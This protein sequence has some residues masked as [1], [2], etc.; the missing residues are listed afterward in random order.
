VIDAAQDMLEVRSG[1]MLLEWWAI[2]LL[3][4]LAIFAVNRFVPPDRASNLLYDAVQRMIPRE[5]SDDILIV[6]IDNHS[7]RELGRWPWRRELHADLMGKLTEAGVRAVGYDIL[8]LEP[9]PV[10]RV[11]RALGAA[12]AAN[13]QTVV[14]HLIE[15]PGRDGRPSDLIAPI[16]AISGSVRT[17]AHVVTRPDRDGVV[18]GVDRLEDPMGRRFLHLSE[19]LLAIAA[20][21]DATI[22]APDPEPSSRVLAPV[23][24]LIP[25]ARGPGAYA[26]V[27]FVDVVRGQVPIELLHDRIILVGATAAG[28]GD[29]F[30]TPMSGTEETM[31][32]VEIHANY[33]DALQAG[34]LIRTAP[35][36]AVQL[37]SLVPLWLLMLSLLR[38]GP[39]INLWLG[40][41]LG[42]VVVLASFLAL[43]VFRLW[44]PPATGLA[45][46]ALIFPLWGWRRLDVANSYMIRELRELTAEQPMLP[47]HRVELRGD[48]VAR[49]IV[50]MH[51][52]IR[53]VRDLRQFI[54]QS[55]DNLPDA[56]LITDLDGRVLIANAAAERLFG[57]RIGGQVEGRPLAAVFATLDTDPA[58][59]DP[60]AAELLEALRHGNLPPDHGYETRLASGQSLEIRLAFFTDAA[61]HPLGWIARFVDITDLRASE[62]QREDALRLLTHD[63]RS[64]QAALLAVLDAEKGRV[65]QDVA[66]RLRR[67][68]HLTLGLAD[69][70][71]QYAR[72]ESGRFNLETFD[73][74][75]ALLDAV[76]DLFPLARAKGIRIDAE[77]SDEGLL[78]SGDRALITRAI[79]NYLSNAIKFSPA[80]S[81]IRA[82]ARA[83]LDRGRAMLEVDDEGRGI[84]QDDLGRLFEPFQRL[85]GPE[86]APA[87]DTSGS[88]LGLAF[89]KAVIERH[90]GRVF[91]YSTEGEGS[92]FGFWLPRA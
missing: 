15:I 25:F 18:R 9:Y 52:A 2:L 82:R 14:P 21:D 1:R 81:G 58:F 41:V 32:G 44:L 69:D 17:L 33:L 26:Q 66:E 40:L 30:S 11:D 43:I 59:P 39:R 71:V 61:R 86:G 88:G 35:E 6:A 47:R 23:K 56:A 60:R 90:Q 16:P 10:E 84:A 73:L 34:R 92:Q 3:A 75:E 78:V 8:F 91:V 53:D 89:V 48:P 29:R 4:S 42:A 54:S 85:A 20:G 72:A 55:L 37:F 77:G 70:F 24:D 64:P 38:L 36:W 27:P 63:M 65:P 68:A 12:F 50:L 87:T 5:A 79:T 31:A 7:L 19:A 80:N 74:S 57:P 49:Q 67:Y 51:E 13:G 28:L 83:G 46:L 62:R 22:D 45:A 76:D